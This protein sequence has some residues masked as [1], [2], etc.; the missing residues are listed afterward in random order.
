MNQVQSNGCKRDMAL[1]DK[2]GKPLIG[3]S[4]IQIV[5]TLLAPE[6]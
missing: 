3:W 5:P 4:L 1:V 6:S 2:F